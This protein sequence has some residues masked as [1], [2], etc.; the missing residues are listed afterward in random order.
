M[1]IVRIFIIL[2]SLITTSCSFHDNM[3][4]T[5]KYFKVYQNGDYLEIAQLLSDSLTIIDNDYSKAYTTSEFYEFFQWDSVFKP[6]IEISELRELNNDIYIKVT[7]YSKRLKYLRNNPLITNQRLSFDSGKLTTIEIMDYE[8]FDLYQ[9][10]SRRD[11][12]VKWI[13]TYQPDLSGFIYDMTKNGAENYL[14]SIE[15]YEEKE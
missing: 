3:K 9:W 12:L 14:K 4:L 5:E 2:F 11:T 7:T 1:T 6:K 10:S 15:L 13:E 8:N